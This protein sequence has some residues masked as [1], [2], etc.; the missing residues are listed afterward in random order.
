M[1]LDPLIASLN[2][3]EEHEP[4]PSGHEPIPA[5]KPPVAM[6]AHAYYGIAGDIVKTIEPHTE[7]DPAAIL[8][9]TLV[10]F[11]VLAGR[12][13]YYQVEGDRHYPNLFALIIGATSKTR[14]GTSWGR[15]RSIFEEISKWPKDN[16]VSGSSTGEGLKYHVRDP[17]Y[18]LNKDGEEVL[19]DAGVEDKRLLVI[20]EEFVQVLRAVARPGNT[21]SPA[22]RTAWN[23]GNMGILTKGDSLRVTGAHIS[24]IGHITVEELRAELTQT[25][26]AN[27]F[28]NR[29][30]FVCA[31][32][33]KFLP[34]GGEGLS[35]KVMLDF[36]YRLA[37]AAEATTFIKK[38]TMTNGAWEVWDSVYHK[39]SEGAPGL[40][41]AA[42]G[43][44][45]AQVARLALVYALLDRSREID[46]PHL[47]AALAVWE[48]AEASARYVF[49]SGLG[50][51]VADDIL[52]ALRAA[53]PKGMNRTQIRDLFQRHRSAEQ[54]EQALALLAKRNLASSRAEETG[55]RSAAVWTSV[56][57]VASVAPDPTPALL[58]AA[59]EETAT[60]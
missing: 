26:T 21:L 24:I 8:V 23:T 38:V 14:K 1:E 47:E 15:V 18:K 2:F 13:A 11:G 30:L 45:E 40:F 48:Y 3:E 27:G 41:G 17:V 34:R 35:E 56:A 59:T 58:P 53:G 36:A 5:P 19:K 31:N 46:V 16:V 25:Q 52:K 10:A 39:L 42:T 28:A 33:S 60:A 12:N 4:N 43:R 50:N 49:G 51:P 29:F 44:A 20:E 32:R 6:G 9:Q 37:L 7:A 54:I 22:V 55:G 57:S